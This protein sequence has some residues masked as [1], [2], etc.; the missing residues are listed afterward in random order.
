MVNL[1]VEYS[2]ASETKR[3]AIAKDI[4]ILFEDHQI[5]T[6]KIHINEVRA[7]KRPFLNFEIYKLKRYY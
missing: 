6:Q 3:I 4:F 7:A 2:F 1:I 5:K